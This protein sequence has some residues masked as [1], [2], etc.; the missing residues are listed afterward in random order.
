MKFSLASLL[1]LSVAAVAFA[2]KPI[3]ARSTTPFKC[4]SLTEL[5]ACANAIAQ[6]GIKQD[7]D[8]LVSTEF[9]TKSGK[10]IDLEN[11]CGQ[12][13]VKK[14]AACKKCI[15]TKC[16]TMPVTTSAPVATPAAV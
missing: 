6:V 1:V 4:H 5:D 3:S 11:V 9:A 8:I 13:N 14:I 7:L 10:I 2:K 16:H 12:V 15:F